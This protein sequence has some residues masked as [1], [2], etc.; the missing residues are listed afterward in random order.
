MHGRALAAVGHRSMAMLE[1]FAG[2]WIDE[3]ERDEIGR[4]GSTCRARP[5]DPDEHAAACGHLTK[6]DAVGALGRR[7]GDRDGPSHRRIEERHARQYSRGGR[8]GGGGRGWG[9]LWNCGGLNRGLVPAGCL[10]RG[11][12]RGHRAGIQKLPTAVREPP[13][14]AR[15][16][17][18]A[19]DDAQS[20][21]FGEE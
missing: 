2:I 8:G 10:V 7:R 3:I 12:F 15:E 21:A 13:Y 6:I 17:E 18:A 11:R 9:R 14:V 19:R 5:S 1:R 16:G 20:G 4:P